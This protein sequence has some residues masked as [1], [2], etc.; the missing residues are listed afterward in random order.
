[1]DTNP[2]KPCYHCG[3]TDPKKPRSLDA[4]DNWLCDNCHTLE[5][6]AQEDEAVY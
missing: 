3:T 1:M 4:D 2:I 5:Q 6:Q